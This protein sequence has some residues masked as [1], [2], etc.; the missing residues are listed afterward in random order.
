MLIYGEQVNKQKEKK[1][2]IK[3]GVLLLAV[4]VPLTSTAAKGFVF[5]GR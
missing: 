1:M 4:L 3:F 2:Q 5:F